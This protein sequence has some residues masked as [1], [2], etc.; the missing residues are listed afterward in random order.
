MVIVMV[1]LGSG[2]Y[3]D[4]IAYIFRK[5]TA[6]STGDFYE[7]IHS[8]GGVTFFSTVRAGFRVVYLGVI[9]ER[10]R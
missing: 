2:V 7:R 3:R 4:G 8:L 5:N 6:K 9:E 10:A 1:Q